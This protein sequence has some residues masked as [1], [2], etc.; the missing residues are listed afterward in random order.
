MTDWKQ[1]EVVTTPALLSF[2]ALF[3]PRPKHTSTPNVLSYQATIIF[4]ASFDVTPL[5]NAINTAR[6]KMERKGVMAPA[7][8]IKENMSTSPN[9]YPLRKS[10]D[11]ISVSDDGTKRLPPGFEPGGHFISTHSKNRPTLVDE[12]VQAVID[13]AKFYAGCWCIFHLGAFVWEANSRWGVSFGLNGVQFVKDGER[14]SGR[15]DITGDFAPIGGGAVD[16]KS[17]AAGG[18]SEDPFG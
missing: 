5:K 1:F 15:P 10:E 8:R 17:A 2:P 6:T 7:K 12:R 18:A 14:L 16:G 13:E 9:G 3:K 11:R 4:P